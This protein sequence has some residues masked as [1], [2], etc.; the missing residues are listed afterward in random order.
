MRRCAAAWLLALLLS[1]PARAEDPVPAPPVETVK[2][3]CSH[4]DEAVTRW[5]QLIGDGSTASYRCEA[6]SFDWGKRLIFYRDKEASKAGVAFTGHRESEGGF[7]V[8]AVEPALLANVPASGRCRLIKPEDAGARR[9]LCFAKETERP[10]RAHLVEMVITEREWPGMAATPGRCSSPGIGEYVLGPWIAQQT[11]SAPL[12]VPKALPPCQTMTIVAGRSF[13]FGT[14]ETRHAVTFLGTIDK[15]RPALLTVKTIV[16]PGGA[17][18]PALAGSCIPQR[19]ADGH[20]TVHCM[21][22][23]IDG[24]TTKYVEVGFI[25]KN[26]R[27]EWPRDSQEPEPVP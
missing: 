8:T 13:T 1:T 21:A 17:E 6:A 20:V 16:L 11:G 7:T 27:F 23:Y 12:L 14:A 22:A 24:G 15:E 10:E 9:V 3:E 2:G 26:S 25:P 4:P 5:L 18:R 19:V